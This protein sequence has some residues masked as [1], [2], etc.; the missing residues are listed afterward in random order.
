MAFD[1]KEWPSPLTFIIVLCKTTF[2]TFPWPLMSKIKAW[3]E[4]AEAAALVEEVIH[5][6]MT[7]NVSD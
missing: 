5:P 1:I 7:P 4:E 2:F 6:I 3:A